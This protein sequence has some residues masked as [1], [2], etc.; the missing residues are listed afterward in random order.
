[1]ISGPEKLL[2]INELAVSEL[3]INTFT[4]ARDKTWKKL[5]KRT[6]AEGHFTSRVNQIFR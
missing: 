2:K 4:A 5:L 3:T 6:V 1:V